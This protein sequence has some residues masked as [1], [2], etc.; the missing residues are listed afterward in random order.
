MKNHIA[1]IIALGLLPTLA[2]GQSD[3]SAVTPVQLKL[4]QTRKFNKAPNETLRA[5]KTY[6]EDVGATNAILSPVFADK[7]GGAVPGT[8]KVTCLYNPKF[9]VSFFGAL[10]NNSP[11][12]QI[13]FEAIDVSKTHIVLRARM[14]GP[15]PDSVQLTDPETYNKLFKG[16]GDTIFTEALVLEAPTQE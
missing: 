3:N 13:K 4:M 5:V 9:T 15:A 10:K 12:S 11:L 7:E 2:F 14:F 6:C 16:I 8:G 1:T